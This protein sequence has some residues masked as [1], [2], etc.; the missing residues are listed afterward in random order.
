MV[1]SGMN[2]GGMEHGPAL[3]ALLYV[4]VLMMVFMI[5]ME[6]GRLARVPIAMR[7]ADGFNARSGAVKLA[8]LF[9]AMSGTV[10]L[11]LVPGHLA[12]DR[13]LGILFAANALAFAGVILATFLTDWWR[14]PALAL[15]VA[16][17]AA[18]A[19]YVL[20][21]REAADAIGVFTQLVNLTAIFL[22]TFEGR[23]VPI[24]GRLTPST[25][26]SE[27]NL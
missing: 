14:L 21:G 25:N 16:T 8:V 27:V 1:M 5:A 18:Y 17:V 6:A 4:P 3:V 12:E 23:L 7:F 2:L 15:L 20:T 19:F 22:I 13:V 11:A 10:H 26:P 24:L 9:M